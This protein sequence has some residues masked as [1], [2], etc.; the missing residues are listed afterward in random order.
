MHLTFCFELEGFPL[1]PNLRI[2]KVKFDGF[3]CPF[4]KDSGIIMQTKI[5]RGVGDDLL[6]KSSCDV[7]GIRGIITPRTWKQNHRPYLTKSLPLVIIM[8]IILIFNYFLNVR[9][10]Y[11]DP[12]MLVERLSFPQSEIRSY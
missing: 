9:L 5:S 10:S 8:F 4:T 11:L 6:L 12:N 2:L 1:N 7:Q 3:A